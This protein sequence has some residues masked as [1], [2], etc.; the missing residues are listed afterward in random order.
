M[1]NEQNARKFCKDDISMIE[2]YEKAIND[3]TQTWHCHHRLETFD[4]ERTRPSRY[5]MMVN[6]Y[7]N[8]PADELIF[9]TPSEHQRIHHTSCK[10][11]KN[12]PKVK[13]LR[14]R[15][16]EHNRKISESLKKYYATIKKVDLL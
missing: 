12:L 2:N 4:G 1:I 11:R 14:K 5:L 3:M 6:M 8:R 9:L 10:L 16:E 7:Y 15:T 13:N